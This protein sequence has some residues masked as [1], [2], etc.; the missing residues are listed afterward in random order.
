MLAFLKTSPGL[1]FRGKD[2]LL[3]L[4]RGEFTRIN[5]DRLPTAGAAQVG[6]WAGIPAP[7]SDCVER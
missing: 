1:A 3:Q 5:G 4:I 2:E 7:A 6:G